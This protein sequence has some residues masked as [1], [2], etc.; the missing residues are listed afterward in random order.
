MV[1][2]SVGV[3]LIDIGFTCVHCFGTCTAM[4]VPCGIVC[5]TCMMM[6][7]HF[8]KCTH[9]AHTWHCIPHS[10]VYTGSY[11]HAHVNDNE[12]E[13]PTLSLQVQASA[14]LYLYKHMHA[15]TYM[16]HYSK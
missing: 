13:V 14:C 7:S 1:N 6:C 10:Y 8:M 4:H 2:V 12:C 9:N 16:P 15:D 5:V 3:L 11:V